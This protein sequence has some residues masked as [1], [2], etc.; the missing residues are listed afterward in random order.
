MECPHSQGLWEKVGQSVGPWGKRECVLLSCSLTNRLHLV[1]F[2]DSFDKFR[3]LATN[4]MPKALLTVSGNP[5]CTH[6]VGGHI[7][8][9]DLFSTGAHRSFAWRVMGMSCE[10]LWRGHSICYFRKNCGLASDSS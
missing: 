7:I 1:L 5:I 8:H 10:S 3:T 4:Q 6:R 9:Q 2:I